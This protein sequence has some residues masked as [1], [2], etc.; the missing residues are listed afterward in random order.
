MKL[1]VAFLHHQRA[2]HAVRALETLGLYHLSISS[3]TV[4]IQP[5]TR[6]WSAELAPHGEGEVRVDAYCPD[7]L[8]ATT[9]ALLR[10]YGRI[11]D[12]PAGALFVH[13][14][15][16]VGLIHSSDSQL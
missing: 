5:D 12:L 2:G 1:I 15:S 4:L 6:T 11:G 10:E 3:T 9:V 8:V 16:E 13:P 14:V 7:D